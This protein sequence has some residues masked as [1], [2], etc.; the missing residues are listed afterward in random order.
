MT[1]SRQ[2]A[3]RIGHEASLHEENSFVTL[4]YNDDHLPDDYS[5]SVRELQL[6]L[7]RLRKSIEPKRVRFYACGEYGEK[8]LRPHYHLI[9]F[10]YQFPDLVVWRRSPTGFYLYRSPALEKLWAK[11]NAEIGQV[12]A[13]SGGYVAR[14]CL[15]KIGGPAADDHYQRLHPITGEICHVHPE[16]ATQST[17]PGIGTNWFKKYERETFPSDFLVVDGQKVP[18]P[19]FYTRKLK[20]RFENEGSQNHPVFPH[21]DIRPIHRKRKEHALSKAD[22]NTPDRLS[23]RRECAELRADRLTRNLDD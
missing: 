5:V 14:Y 15:K 2:W 1:R 9:L 3:A 4:T 18:V 12:T 19:S 16:F 6:F 10:G 17:Q 22:D 11:G 7:K 13:S 21:D 23:V 20:D 8:T